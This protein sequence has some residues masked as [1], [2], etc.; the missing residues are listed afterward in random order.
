MTYASA[1]AAIATEALGAANSIPPLEKVQERI[2]NQKKLI[3]C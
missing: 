1:A 3:F 2:K